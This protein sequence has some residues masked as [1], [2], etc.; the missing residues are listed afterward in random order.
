MTIPGNSGSVKIG[1][2]ATINQGLDD[3][4]WGI[5]NLTITEIRPTPV[6]TMSIWGLGVL[7]GLFGLMGL[8][9]RMK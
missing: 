5:D 1:F 4:S 8:R 2:G 7:S 9:R 6:P 3:E